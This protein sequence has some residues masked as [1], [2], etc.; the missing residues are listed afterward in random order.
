MT[1]SE[2]TLDMHAKNPK[3]ARGREDGERD[4]VAGSNL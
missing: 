3:M 1:A 2:K 4:R